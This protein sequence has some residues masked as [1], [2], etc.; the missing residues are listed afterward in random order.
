MP[1]I[2]HL[3]STT[4]GFEGQRIARQLADGLG[5][6]FSVDVRTIGRRGDLP[7]II[8][9]RPALRRGGWDI[10]HAWDRV[11]LMGAVITGAQHVVV[12]PPADDAPRVIRLARAAMAHRAVQVVCPTA[13]IH[14]LAVE[15]GIPV[16]R[17][18][19]IRPGVDFG[20]VRQRRDRDLRQELGFGDE[21]T[22]LLAAGEST[23]AGA[24]EL[25]VWAMSILRVV[26]RNYRLLLW[27]RGPAVERVEHI[28]RGI[29]DRPSTCFAEQHLG[30]PIAYEQLHAAA[31]IVLV[32]ARETVDTLPIATA[33]A[34]GLPIISTAT[35]AP[36]ELLEDRHTALM[37]TDPQARLIAQRVIDL[38][39]DPSLQW[40]IADMARNEAYAYFSQSRMID[41]YRDFYQQIAAGGAVAV[42]QPPPA[43]GVRFHGRA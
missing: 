12:T 39:S 21:D 27:G 5:A 37:V 25:A 30:R 20:R 11:S 14:R 9:G 35:P 4:G 41:Q 3:Q 23:A 2:C 42:H 13:T 22:V 7:G 31:D 29:G 6:P 32:T 43:A 24:H 10:V 36:S 28:A 26:H 1:R 8:R 40:R 15:R 16:E 33:M 34:G 19:L 38:R 17:C 18:H